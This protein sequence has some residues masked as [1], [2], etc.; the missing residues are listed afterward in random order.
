M[1]AT[2]NEKLSYS[3]GV[4]AALSLKRFLEMQ[5][6]GLDMKLVETGFQDGL[7][8]G[9]TL[10]KDQEIQEILAVFQKDI[11]AKQQKMMAQQQEKM[12][13]LGEKNKKEGEKF[14]AENKNQ[15]GVKTLPSGLQYKVIQEGTGVSPKETDK[16]TVHYRGTLID[17]AE[18]DSSYKR[19]TPVTFPVNGVIKGWTEA[20]KLMKAGSKWKLFIPSSL[21]YGETGT[22]GGP[23][24]PN[25]VLVFEVELIS[26]GK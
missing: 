19:G 10:L 13:A 12:K 23:I 8:G 5:S 18:F 2:E 9:N 1:P 4:N 24:G 15:K 25:A 14:L 17:G 26:I 6:V 21:A 16:A 3:M 11:N 20:L 7:Q 22:P